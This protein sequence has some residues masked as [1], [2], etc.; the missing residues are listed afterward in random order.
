[1]VKS[2]ET[3]TRFWSAPKRF[4]SALEFDGA[5]DAQLDFVIAVANLRA[6][7]FGI[8]PPP[9]H[10]ADREMYSAELVSWVAEP[11]VPRDDVN[12]VTTPGGEDEEAAPEAAGADNADAAADLERMLADLGPPG[13]GSVGGQAIELFPQTFEKDDDTNFHMDFITAASNLRARNYGIKESD[14]LQSKLIAGKIIPAIPT[15]TAMVTGLVCLE[16]YKL[17]HEDKRVSKDPRKFCNS[18]VNL[19]V[20]LLVLSEPLA[21]RKELHGDMAWDRWTQW[22]FNAEMTLSELLAELGRRGLEVQGINSGAVSWIRLGQIPDAV[23]SDFFAERGDQAQLR[24]RSLS[25][26]TTAVTLTI[27]ATSKLRLLVDGTDATAAGVRAAFDGCFDMKPVR[28]GAWNVEFKTSVAAAAALGSVT[29]IDGTPVA[30][31]YAPVDNLPAIELLLASGKDQLQRT[32]TLGYSRDSQALTEPIA[33]E[34]EPLAELGSPSGSPVGSPESFHSAEQG[35][36]GGG[37]ENDDDLSDAGFDTIVNRCDSWSDLSIAEQQAANI[38][39][40]SDAESGFPD[41]V[42]EEQRKWAELAPRAQDAAAVLMYSESHWNA[43]RGDDSDSDASS[44]HSDNE[45]TRVLGEIDAQ[46]TSKN[47]LYKQTEQ[48]AVSEGEKEPALRDASK[49]IRKSMPQS[50]NPFGALCQEMHDLNENYLKFEHGIHTRSQWN[51]FRV[52]TVG[53]D[54]HEWQVTLTPDA[55]SGQLKKDLTRCCQEYHGLQGVE[56]QFIFKRGLHPFYPPQLKLLRPRFKGGLFQALLTDRTFLEEAG[57]WSPFNTMLSVFT[58]VV[59]LVQKHGVVDVGSARNARDEGAYTDLENELVRLELLTKAPTVAA[60]QY[61]AL[62]QERDALTEARAKAMVELNLGLKKKSGKKG[63]SAKSSFRYGK[64]AT[65]DMGVQEAKHKAADFLLM[66][67]I[68]R[69]VECLG[70]QTEMDEDEQL[71]CRDSCLLPLIGRQLQHLDLG[72]IAGVAGR[73]SSRLEYAQFMVRAAAI[74]F[75]KPFLKAGLPSVMDGLLALAAKGSR[76][77][78][79]QGAAS[80]EKGGGVAAAAAPK[81]PP[82]I[83]SGVFGGGA[84]KANDSELSLLAFFKETNRVVASCEASF[85]QMRS[86]SDGDSVALALSLSRTESDRPS[87]E[88]AYVSATRSLLC[89]EAPGLAERYF[90]SGAMYVAASR[91]QEGGQVHIYIRILHVLRIP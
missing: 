15:T 69:V 19:S 21:P 16:L 26:S 76:Y 81:D 83:T 80:P 2:G 39:W 40:G 60:E 82:D 62:Y 52:D 49:E 42:Y 47:S 57:A 29:S 41:V 53:D 31:S 89:Q 24:T 5:D 79:V 67:N 75:E 36:S 23:L 64:E 12:I 14:K 34:R 51:K 35:G 68:R 17:V 88:L 87:P 43:E 78:A 30:V 28:V 91:S 18:F 32:I 7:T 71:C 48:R 66:E 44:G 4:P 54:I 22:H 63:A 58:D 33:I 74:C 72:S 1:M 77:L 50:L 11:F 45:T 3:M 86:G 65:L 90:A 61:P 8:E 84:G 85:E 10:R 20:P 25:E 59:S 9:G 46:L 37:G 6:R 38:I 13:T 73:G 55:F 70:A 27:S 56:M